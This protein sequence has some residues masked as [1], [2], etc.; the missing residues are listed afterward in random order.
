MALQL[1]IVTPEKKIFSG[2]VDNVYFSGVEGEMGV[3]EAHVALVTG[4]VP[5]ELRYAQGG[6]VQELAV[7]EG[8]VEVTGH[9][10]T[11]LTDLAASD[12]QIDEAKVEEAM[13]RAEESLAKI[14]H[15]ENSEEVAAMQATIAK[16]MA[17]LKLK[18]KRKNI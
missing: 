2:E 17:Q 8:F 15:S 11:V 7:G 18:R 5:G 14:D 10:V 1:D 3:L 16:S 13:R 9:K 4:L 6:K 12:A